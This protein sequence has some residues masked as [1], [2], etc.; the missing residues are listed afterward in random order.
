MIR[1]V[2]AFGLAIVL[3]GCTAGTTSPQ[4]ASS[5]SPTASV[6][7][8]TER[9]APLPATPTPSPTAAELVEPNGV[10]VYGF[11]DGLW[12]VN[13]DGTN[14][15]ELLP[16]VPGS[17]PL[18]WSRDGSRLLYATQRGIALIDAARSA[19]VELVLQCP[20]GA[21]SDAVL[22]SCQVD[23]AGL[24]LSPDGTR[25]AYP[26][27]EG[28]HDQGNTEVTSVLVVLDLET[29]L[30]T[31]LEST[32]VTSRS[33][34]CDAANSGGNHSPSWSSDGRRLLFARASGAG[35][36]DGCQEA[37]LTVNVD[38]SD[39]R[40]MVAPGQLRG[41]L[42]PRW[43][44]DGSS[45]LVGATV[46]VTGDKAHIGGDIYTVRSGGTG[47]HAVTSDGVSFGPSWTRDG[48]IVFIRWSTA[49]DGVYHGDQ[50]VMDADGGNA[51]R[52]EST[53]PALTAAGC[54]ICAYSYS[55][56]DSG[57][58]P[59]DPLAVH[60]SPPIHMWET[61]TMLWQPRPVDQP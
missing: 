21:D 5:P 51:R 36:K 42:E 7:P 39:V 60:Q 2:T 27:W 11:G 53:I 61:I 32:A 34:A 26:I 57:G 10:V 35:A 25:L 56:F 44:P 54:M 18:A 48:R 40:Q 1:T 12:L 17:Q 41:P 29:E 45:I 22:S 50:W 4:R 30:A 47:L 3:V 43:S 9:A 20:L 8:A 19:P 13:A 16:D 33:E 15:H 37:V 28:T 52:V 14:A 46:H 38:D 24:A 6:P 55:A 59:I 49:T 58:S 31:R 23:Q